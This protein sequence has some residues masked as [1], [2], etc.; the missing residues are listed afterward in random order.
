MFPQDDIVELNWINDE[1]E[2]LEQRLIS[3]LKINTPLPQYQMIAVNGSYTAYCINPGDI[4]VIDKQANTVCM[5]NFPKE[6][7]LEIKV[8]AS[9]VKTGKDFFF[10]WWLY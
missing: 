5:M 1:Y 8:R 6:Y 10:L 3:R 7:P 4:R 2:K 9:I